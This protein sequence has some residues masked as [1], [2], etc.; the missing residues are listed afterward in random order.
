[1]PLSPAEAHFQPSWFNRNKPGSFTD[2]V[3]HRIT[4]LKRDWF[5]PQQFK[6][7]RQPEV[8]VVYGSQ[9]VSI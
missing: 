2:V 1:V 4:A 6:M 5:D 3:A 8:A 7:E 9:R